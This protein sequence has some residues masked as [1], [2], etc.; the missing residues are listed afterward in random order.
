MSITVGQI[1]FCVQDIP[2]AVEDIVRE[3]VA[4]GQKFYFQLRNSSLYLFSSYKA[5]NC[6][7]LTSKSA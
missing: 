5:V 6:V 4:R 1:L 3:I 7:S 2:S